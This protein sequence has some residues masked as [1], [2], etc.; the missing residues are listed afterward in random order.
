[1]NPSSPVSGWD[2]TAAGQRCLVTSG[3]RLLL[4]LRARRARHRFRR[5][6]VYRSYSVLEGELASAPLETSGRLWPLAPLGVSLR[7]GDGLPGPFGSGT[8]H[9]VAALEYAE[10]QGVLPRPD[11]RYPLAAARA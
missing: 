6:Q 9:A 8:R 3:G 10:L 7:L 1:M 5:R 4:E 2:E 11:R